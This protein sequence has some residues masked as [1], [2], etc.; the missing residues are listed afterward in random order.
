[1]STHDQYV[2]LRVPGPTP[3]PEL[4]ARAGARPMVNHR[5]PEFAASMLD[6][7]R[8]LKPFFGTE[9][10]PLLLTGSGTAGLEAAL[11]NVLSPGDDVLSVTGGVFGDR[12]AAIA[13]AFGA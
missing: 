12:F 11:V 6:V 10:N 8:G 7:V 2:N 1:M 13:E 3:V 4:V 5:G 9:Q